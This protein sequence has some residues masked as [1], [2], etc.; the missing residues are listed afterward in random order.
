MAKERV[1]N[2]KATSATFQARGIVS[3][4]KSKN[5]YSSGTT[6]SGSAWNS[7]QFGLTINNDKTIYLTLKGFM[8]DKVYYYNSTEKKTVGVAWNQRKQS[9]GEGFRLIGTNI[10][11]GIDE[12][13]G[14]NINEM[15]VEYDAVEYLHEALKDGESLFIKGNVE[16]STFTKNGEVVKKKELVPTQISYTKNP[17][18]FDAENFEEEALFD[19]VLVY[20]GIEKEKDEN[21]KDT[22]RFILSGYSVSYS[23]VVPVSFIIEQKNSKL[24]L[25]LKKK[26]RVGNSIHTWGRINVDVD[27]TSVEDEEDDG[28]GETSKMENNRL[29]KH[30][31]R[32]YVIFRADPS[33]IDTDTY[34]EKDIQDAIKKIKAA[35]TAESNFNGVA[36]DTD[37]WGDDAGDDGEA[38]W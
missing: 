7:L 18:D 19:N 14:K 25:N 26:L 5:F 4:V 35:K 3:G 22:G 31:T 10:S 29:N 37:D 1:H 11:T 23:D 8:R 20:S 34:S 21:D 6:K 2:L 17:V 33:T 36:V 13:S 32:E 9:P 38:P 15:F 16:F 28:W 30:V 27:V 24:A 12:Q